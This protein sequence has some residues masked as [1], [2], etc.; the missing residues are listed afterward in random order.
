[1]GGVVEVR[2]HGRG[3][4]GAVTAA[5]VLAEVALKMGRMSRPFQSMALRGQGL[6]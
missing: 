1:M 2:W 5:K 4:Q 3:G 6:P